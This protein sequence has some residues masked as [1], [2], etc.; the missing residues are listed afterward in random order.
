M[1]KEK[2]VEV[3]AH[4]FGVTL[5]SIPWPFLDAPGDSQLRWKE[6]LLRELKPGPLASEARIIPLDQA[7]DVASQKQTNN[8]DPRCAQGI[9]VAT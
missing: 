5:P 1:D 6:G 2:L 3:D 8:P 9:L 4:E 7:A